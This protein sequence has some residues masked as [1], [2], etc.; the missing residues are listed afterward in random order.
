MA[1]GMVCLA[2]RDFVLGQPVPKNFPERTALAY[3]A[4]GTGL[5]MSEGAVKVAVHRL[6]E[7]YREALRL[8]VAQTLSEDDAPLID[9]ELTHLLAAMRNTL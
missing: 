8:E 7:R 1:L 4:A 3:A 2:W 6:R 5:G 9:A